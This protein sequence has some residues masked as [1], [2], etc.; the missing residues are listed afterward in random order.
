M[1]TRALITILPHDHPPQFHLIFSSIYSRL[2]R[3]CHV[4]LVIR[5]FEDALDASSVRERSFSLLSINRSLQCRKIM[6]LARHRRIISALALPLYT[7]LHYFNNIRT[8]YIE[9]RMHGGDPVHSESRCD[10]GA[11]KL[12]I[13]NVLDGIFIII[14]II[15]RKKSILSLPCNEQ[16]LRSIVW[17]RPQVCAQPSELDSLSIGAST[18]VGDLSQSSFI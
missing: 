16:S 8:L 17:H 6:L 7:L 1:L 3:T 13:F 4:D 14:F 12:G 10:K 9:K 11:T 18:W 2:N 5:I 15:N